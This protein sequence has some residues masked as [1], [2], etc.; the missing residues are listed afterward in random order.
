MTRSARRNPLTTE[1]AF[2]ALQIEGGLLAADWLAKVAQ[3]K[4]PFQ[5]EAD[6]RVPKGLNLRDEIGRYWRIAQAYWRD[7]SAG[8]SS[9][10]SATD[11]A[12][13]FVLGLL[14]DVFGFASLAPTDTI[15]ESERFFPIRFSA[16]NSRVPVVI[17]PVGA[18]LDSPSSEFGDGSRRRSPFALLQE[19]LNAFSDATWGLVCDAFTL[20]LAHDNA[21]LTRPAWVEADLLRIFTEELYPDFAALWL[22]IHESRFGKL[23]RAQEPS[24]LESWLIEGREEGIVAREKLANG[25][26]K[27]VETLGQA[28]LSHAA[29]GALRSALQMGRLTKEAYF[30]QLLRLLY[31]IIFLLTAEERDLLHMKG[32]PKSTRELYVAGYAI[33]NVRNRSLRR[34]AHD[35]NIDQWEAVKIVFRGLAGGESRLGLPA[36][37]GLF[38]LK[39]CPDLDA[40]RLENRALLTAVFQLCFLREDS[41]IERVNWRDMGPD[42]LG[43]IYEGL[44]EL[45][46]TITEEGR[47]FSFAGTEESRG[48]IRKTTGSYYTPDELVKVLL[49]SALDPVIAKTVAAHPANSADAVLKL[50]IVD[51]TCGSGHFLIAAARRLAEHVVRLRTT[52]TPTPEEYRRALR[53]VVRHCVY[54]VDA[55]PLAVELCKVS[56]WME[57]VTPGSPLT[58]LESHIRNGNSL[59]GTTGELMDD[60]IPDAAWVSLEGDDESVTRLLRNRNRDEFHGQR[61]LSWSDPVHSEKILEAMEALEDAPDSDPEALARKEK[62][63]EELLASQ[64]YEH[65]RLVADAWCAAFFWPKAELGAPSD[66]APTTAVWRGLRDRQGASQILVET[67]GKIS[68]DYGLFHWDQAFPN[69]FARGGFDVVLGNPPWE[70]VKIQEQEFFA[71]RDPSIANARN[72]AERKKRIA[73]LPETNPTLW[74]EWCTASRVAQGTSHFFRQS[75]RYP[76]S[77][78]GDIN[79]YALFVEHNWRAINRSGSAGFIVPSGIVTDDTTKELFQTLVSGKVLSSVYHFENED[80]VFRG[81]HHAYRFVLMTIGEAVNTDFVFYA[82]RASQLTDLNRH[83]SLSADDIA[84]LNPNTGTSPTFRSRRDADLNLKL[85]KRTGILWRDDDREGNPWGMQFLRM[86]DMANDSGMFRTSGELASAGWDLDGNRFVKDG[87]VMLPLCEAKMFHHYDHRFGTYA[88]QTEAQARQ[89][90]LPE[91]DDTAH[92]DPS[93]VTLP[94][95]WVEGLEVEERLAGRWDRSWLLGWR[96]ITGTEKRRTVIAAVVP[97]AGVNDKFLL[98]LPFVPARLVACLYGNLCSFPFDYAARQKVGGISLKYFTMRQLPTLKPS[99]YSSPTP[100]AHSMMLSEWLLSRILELTYT[101][102]DLQPFA[103]DCGDDG[104][105]YFWDSE[106]R[107]QLRS[108]VDAA[109]FH[110]YGISPCDA[111]YIMDSFPVVRD[112][113]QRNHGEFRT[114]R[115]ILEIY[116]ALAKAEQTGRPYVS[117]LGPPTRVK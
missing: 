95:Y 11:L 80:R 113:D 36:L 68:M 87:R 39:H 76:L 70:R 23:D 25:F 13:Q 89:G 16:M 44:L 105:P 58:F 19:Y 90:K 21:S 117:S 24:P 78:Q 18:G 106:R 74:I 79:T 49:D 88:G 64:A 75:G 82:R 43:Y 15:V 14:R 50:A 3:L 53:D 99:S 4:A 32:T 31:R 59:L 110:L 98:M 65:N 48:H 17:G 92:Q 52:T 67:I 116:D 61:V 2:D 7:L 29:N 1:I 8:R 115:V 100:W 102:W 66:A 84:A 111:E 114:K 6:Y 93:F 27:A 28:F 108:E 56:L 42:E 47:R 107:F 83:F 104:P 26:E 20:R 33:L 46:P 54:G 55:N 86:F 41:G 103:Q 51:P 71:K 81:L 30:A 40:A 35:H 34:S 109:Y 96:D 12:D 62:Q 97:R 38:A 9:D 112:A 60:R 69:V 72:A 22:L 85:Y 57:S 5:S 73:A 45:V 94:R 77:A 37:A 10:A 91:L 101:A 63:W